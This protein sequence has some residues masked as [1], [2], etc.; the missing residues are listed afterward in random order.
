MS[1]NNVKKNEI[2]NQLSKKEYD[3]LAESRKDLGLLETA[4]YK[5]VQE[6][7][8]K[9]MNNIFN[10]IKGLINMEIDKNLLDEIK[11]FKSDDIEYYYNKF[12]KSK[13]DKNI[14]IFIMEDDILMTKYFKSLLLNIIVKDKY[15]KNLKLLEEIKDDKET[16]SDDYDI[17]SNELDELQEKIKKLEKPDPRLTFRKR[18]NY[19]LL[20]V[21]MFLIY[22][23]I[24]SMEVML[25]QA[26]RLFYY[27]SMFLIYTFNFLLDVFK[28][29]SYKFFIILSLLIFICK[30][31]NINFNIFRNFFNFKINKLKN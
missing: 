14:T 15:S 22:T 11:K 7:K 17:I 23:I 28:L 25:D 12:K 6:N 19:F 13:I 18:L 31:C 9:N 30:R 29:K 10:Q 2:L 16:L 1:E 8:I 5:V 20:A 4:K 21:I 27:T 24:V 26:F 3:E